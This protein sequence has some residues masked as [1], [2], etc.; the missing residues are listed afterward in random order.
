MGSYLSAEKSAAKKT[1]LTVEEWRARRAAGL[2]HCFRCRAWHPIEMFSI[3][4]SRAQGRTAS[5]KACT[6]LAST[7]SR[8]GMSIAKLRDLLVRSEG[9]CQL[10][11]READKLVVDHNHDTGRV[12][13]I[14]CS[15]CNVGMGLFGDDPAAMRAAADYLE[16][17]DG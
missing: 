15:S 9:R 4:K 12:R 6:S 2:R 10:C 1:G 14:L 16:R 8:Y 11:R 3:D 13:G 5:C 7:A 17:N